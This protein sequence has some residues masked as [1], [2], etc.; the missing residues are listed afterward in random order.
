VAC[1]IGGIVD[2]SNESWSDTSINL[3]AALSTTL[4][5]SLSRDLDLGL[6]NGTG[7]PPQPVGVIGV[8][9][10]AVGADL[11]A[12]VTVAKGQIGDAGGT[13]TTLAISATALATEDGKLAT[14][15]GLVYPDGFAAAM[16]LTPVVVPALATPLVYDKSRCFLV[17][18]N[19]STAEMSRDYHFQYDATSIRV[20]ARVAAGLP[21]VNKAIRKCAT[22]MAAREADQQR[23][24]A[25]AGRRSG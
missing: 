6:L 11:L 17:V 5:D 25:S 2:L 20:K 12:Q 22:A 14:G 19:D 16:G 7:V 21:D 10:T 1:K 3:T 18:R 15:G 13:P 24:R 4:Q 23:E 9:P 8:A